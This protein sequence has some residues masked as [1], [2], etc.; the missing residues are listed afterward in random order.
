MP[1]GPCKQLASECDLLR[2]GNGNHWQTT[3]TTTIYCA[4]VA[5]S[6]KQVI[7]CLTDLSNIVKVRNVST[8]LTQRSQ[9]TE[10][11]QKVEPRKNCLEP[12]RR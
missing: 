11:F 1:A 12:Q 8:D 4:T 7:F 2:Y 5:T 9:R 3:L 6:R 10:D